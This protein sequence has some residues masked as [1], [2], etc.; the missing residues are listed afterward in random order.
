M[1]PLFQLS[2]SPSSAGSFACFLSQFCISDVSVEFL[3]KSMYLS[4]DFT[5][6]P[7]G[8]CVE[9]ISSRLLV[10]TL[11]ISSWSFVLF[12]HLGQ[13]YL[14]SHFGSLPVFISVYYV[15]LLRLLGLVEL[16]YVIGFL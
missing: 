14:S 11:F 13:V 1:Y 10:S 3:A 15:E 9:L 12:F 4:P 6:R 5:E 7:Y 8:Q 2:A 16:P